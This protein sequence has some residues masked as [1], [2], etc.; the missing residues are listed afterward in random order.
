MLMQYFQR[1]RR[2]ALALSGVH[3]QTLELVPSERPRFESLGW[4][5]LT[6]SCL[7]AISMWF[8]LASAVGINGLLA[9]PVAL[10]WGI[11]I[12]GIDRWLVTSM[13]IDENRKWLIALPRVLLAILLGTLISTPLVLR[14]F[15]SEINAQIAKM[16]QTNYNTYLQTQG[17][18]QLAK[19]ITTYSTELAYLNTVINSTARRPATPR[20]TRS[21]SLTTSS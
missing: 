15:Q 4:S 1:L 5:I 8:A 10:F 17:K 12:M 9:I 14:V 20:P 2:F 21:S 3:L 19:Q 16:Q 7:A 11:V 18:D 13:P 6:T